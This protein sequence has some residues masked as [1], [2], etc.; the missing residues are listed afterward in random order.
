MDLQTQYN[1]LSTEITECLLLKSQGY[2]Y[3]HGNK[4]RRL[5]AHQ[6]K[7]RSASEQIPQIRKDDGELTIHP[8]EIKETFTTFYSNLYTSEM[9]NDCSDMQHFF[10]NLQAPSVKIVHGT[11]TELPLNRIEITTAIKAMQNGK[12][13]GP[14]GYPIEF[15][16]RFFDKLTTIL[17]DMFND[18]LAT[19][20]LSSGFHPQSN[21]QTERLNQELE[22]A[23]RCLVSKNPSTW[24]EQLLWVEYAH[25]TLSSSSTHLSPF[26]C[27]YIF[28]P[29][30]FPSQEREASCQ[31]TLTFIRRCRLTWT[32]APVVAVLLLHIRW[33]RRSSS[34]PGT[35]I[36]GWSQPS[37]RRDISVPSRFRKS[38]ILWW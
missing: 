34:P 24:A 35:S 17:L 20:S 4:A 36:F 1:L 7:C 9:T 6:L 37:W 12:T 30:P 28:Q 29:P 27:A 14:D 10:N 33:G 23:L 38:L 2:I 31:S 11:E 8:E 22:T 18:S 13:P 5:L 21:G 16:K 25:N 26:Q 3:E 19:A 15:Y 32:K